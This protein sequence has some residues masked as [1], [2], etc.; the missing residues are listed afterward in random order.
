MVSPNGYY[1][2]YRENNFG[3]ILNLKPTAENKSQDSYY[4]GVCSNAG[5]NKDGVTSFLIS[6]FSIFF[7]N[8]I[9]VIVTKGM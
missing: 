8:Y 5:K 1:N 7:I 6:S 3:N 9:N 4:P 2:I